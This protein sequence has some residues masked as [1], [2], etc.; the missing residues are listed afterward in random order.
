MLEYE[1]NT[2]AGQSSLYTTSNP[3]KKIPPINGILAYFLTKKLGNDQV[4]KWK[5]LTNNLNE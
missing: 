1:D 2:A 3:N 5:I 4:I